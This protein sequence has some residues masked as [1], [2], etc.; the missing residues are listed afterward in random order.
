MKVSKKLAIRAAILL[1]ILLAVV[2]FFYRVPWGFHKEYQGIYYQ[3]GKPDWSE[4][5][6]I[7]FDGY[8]QRGVWQDDV[9]DGK[10]T[11]GDKEMHVKLTFYEKSPIELTYIYNGNI[12]MY[13][14]MYAKDFK[15]GFAIWVTED[16]NKDQNNGSSFGEGSYLIAAPA[17][18]RDE[19]VELT[20]KL[21]DFY[22]IY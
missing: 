21:T 22:P 20:K 1:P 8:L 2:Y 17:D 18:N 19:A 6:A 4:K 16:D 14:V 10:L 15:K 5:V 9:F 11:I 12:G 3:L 7:V 13:G